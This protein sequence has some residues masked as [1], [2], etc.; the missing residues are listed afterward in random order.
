MF[1]GDQWRP[2]TMA[3]FL[4]VL[5][6]ITTLATKRTPDSVAKWRA[7][8]ATSLAISFTLIDS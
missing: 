6:T 2:V 7:A 1:S 8:S 3:L 4:A 5:V